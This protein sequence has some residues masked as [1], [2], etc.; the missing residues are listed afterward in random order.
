MAGTSIKWQGGVDIDNMQYMMTIDRD[1]TDIHSLLA[2]GMLIPQFGNVGDRG[3]FMGG[4]YLS[5]L[6]TDVIQYITISTPGNAQ[7]FGD[8]VV[9]RIS[10]GCC[11]NNANDRGIII[12]GQGTGG[13]NIQE[14]DY[15]TISTTGNANDFGNLGYTKRMCSAC[16]N[17]INERGINGVGG[18]TTNEVNSIDYVTINSPG[19]ATD[20]GNAIN[21]IRNN[22]GTSNAT[23]ERGVFNGGRLDGNYRNYIQ[24][25]TI[26]STGNATDAANLTAQTQ[27]PVAVSNATNE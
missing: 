7:D 13:G 15:V 19:N 27:S 10:A 3:I 23:N 14:I 11:S 26:N 20:F 24:Y 12:A 25:I 9:E 21:N 4:Y 18:Y 1:S 6:Y 22:A 8:L 17:G 5:T 2:D 16:S